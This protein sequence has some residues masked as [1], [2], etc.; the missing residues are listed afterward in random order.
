MPTL[1]IVLAAEEAAG[2]QVL[3][4]LTAA[5]VRVATVLTTRPRSGELARGATVWHVAQTLGL[6][7]LDAALIKDAALS[8]RI[9]DEAVDLLLNVHSLHVAHQAVIQSPRCGAFNLHPGPLPE[10]AGLN[11]PSWAVWNE[12]TEYGVTLHRMM[13]TIDSGA[14]AYQTRWSV[15]PS[16]TGYS[17][18]A[19]CVREGVKLVRLLVDAA[20]ADPASIPA[21]PQDLTRR[22]LYRRGDR[23]H[24]LRLD[25]SWPAQTA[26]RLVRAA[27]FHPLPSPWGTP[28]L[29]QDGADEGE[30]EIGI[31]RA[32][33]IDAPAASAARLGTI[34][35]FEGQ[36]AIA[37]ASGWLAPDLVCQ[38]GQLRSAA[39]LLVPGMRLKSPA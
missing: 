29:W 15:Q 19:R 4:A 20:Q 32:Q 14:I 2:V 8:V 26:A 25:L 33:A 16:D 28:F 13:A 1:T 34:T 30:R 36:V 22:R 5:G 39:D 9:R 11:C 7:T 21:H 23:P 38:A 6:P 18:S 17:L 3:R 10:Y 37:F 12:A 24:G 27:L 31:V 35:K